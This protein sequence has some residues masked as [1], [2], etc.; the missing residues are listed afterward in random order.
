MSSIVYELEGQRFGKLIVL[1]RLEKIN[2][3]SRWLVKCDCGNEFGVYQ[4]GLLAKNKPTRM[5]KKCARKL[6]GEKNLNDLTGQKFGKWT[7]LKRVKENSK[8][9]KYLCRCECG[10]EHIVLGTTLSSGESTKCKKC[11]YKYAIHYIHNMSNTRLY[12]I[13]VD[14]KSRCNKNTSKV[15]K[16]YGGKGVKVCN[17]WSSDFMNFYNWAITNGYQDHLTIDRIDVNGNYEPA[18]CRWITKQEQ[19]NN[20][21]TNHFITYN[22]ETHTIKQWSNITGLSQEVIFGRIVRYKWAVERALTEPLN[23]KYARNNKQ[24]GVQV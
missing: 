10:A 14:M 11:G 2:H 15:Y 8:R 5:C 19:A 9:V 23:K 22:G 4:A 7:V 21:T 18:N 12:T 17:E 20:K 3:R 6:V 16:Y 1:K 24:M 13:W